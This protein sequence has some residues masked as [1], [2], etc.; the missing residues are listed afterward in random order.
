MSEHFVAFRATDSQLRK[1]NR[2]AAGFGTTRSAILR[3]LVETA[4]IEPVTEER[5]VGTVSVSANDGAKVDARAA[6]A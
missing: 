4:R 1:L 5:A 3:S 2:L 6:A